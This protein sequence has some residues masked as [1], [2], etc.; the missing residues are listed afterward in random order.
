MKQHAEPAVLALPGGSDLMRQKQLWGIQ[1]IIYGACMILSW[2]TL[3]ILDV[4]APVPLGTLP[5]LVLAGS[6]ISTGA[7]IGCLSAATAV[8]ILVLV[9]LKCAQH[10]KK[11]GSAALTAVLILDLGINVTFTATSWWYLLA[12]ALDILLLFL[13]LRMS[14]LCQEMQ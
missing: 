5:V 6:V 12:I 8:Y 14:F 2:L 9:C 4:T 3:W 7:L 1:I 10:G 11:A 13:L